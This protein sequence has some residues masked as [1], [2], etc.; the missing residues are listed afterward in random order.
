M[1]NIDQE[2]ISKNI[3][4][5]SCGLHPQIITELIYT[6]SQ[7]EPAIE[8]QE[9]HVVTTQ[10]GMN[11]IKK[12]LLDEVNGHFHKLCEEYGLKDTYFHTKNIGLLKNATDL[13]MHDIQS[14][15]DNEAVAN[16]ITEV[17]RTLTSQ[18][19]TKLFVSLAG[20]RRTI[21]YYLGYA[22]SLFGRPQDRLS[23]IIVNHAYEADDE[24]F[25]PNKEP[26]Y[27]TDR[28]GNTLNTQDA[29]ITLA[30]IPFVRLR[31]GLPANL[32]HGKCSFTEAVNSIPKIGKTA[33]V[34]IDIHNKTIIC[35]DV[36]ISLSP[37]QFAWYTWI[38]IRRK[39]DG[40]DNGAIHEMDNHH[41]DFLK[42]FKNIYGEN[43]FGVE[44]A[45]KAL[46]NPTGFDI[47][48]IC[49]KNSIVNKRLRN[50]LGNHYPQF[51]ISPFGERPDTKYSVPLDPENII[52]KDHYRYHKTVF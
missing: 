30:E 50:A 25:Y 10:I 21:S 51:F 5:T 38:L 34:Q 27:I 12:Y 1:D 37:I 23:H 22:L 15:D 47:N 11:Q 19:N 39:N 31:E 8:F 36:Q 33:Q 49:E 32:L 17:V 3:L 4:L 16:Q 46:L 35:N 43:H 20:G 13:P 44:R 29:N 52:I 2:K 41:L 18:D 6:M 28:K 26:T 48:Y 42:T 24:F 14:V 40:L 7:R 45:S 9:I